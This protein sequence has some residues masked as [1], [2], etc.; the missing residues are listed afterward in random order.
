MKN[1]ELTIK[2]KGRSPISISKGPKFE[3]KAEDQR[4]REK[5]I[6]AAEGPLGARAPLH[7]RVCE[8]ARY[9][10]GNM[11]LNRESTENVENFLM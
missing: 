9:A 8:G 11:R 6:P 3:T 10:T 2:I 4:E 7:S 5:K 1:P